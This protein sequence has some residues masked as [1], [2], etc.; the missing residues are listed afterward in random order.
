[1][2]HNLTCS[3]I[4][5]FHSIAMDDNILYEEYTRK[6]LRYKEARLNARWRLFTRRCPNVNDPH[7]IS[8]CQRYENEARLWNISL[9]RSG[10]NYTTR[11]FEE[12]WSFT[13]TMLTCSDCNAMIRY[14][15]MPKNQRSGPPRFNICCHYGQVRLDP[16]PAPAPLLNSLFNNRACV[17]NIRTY[18]SMM[19]FTS[20]S[21]SMWTSY[22]SYK[23]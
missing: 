1:M 9:S 19:S 17:E 4:I 14:D 16:L 23:R 20:I 12:R 7:Y 13:R 22:I 3:T 6:R 8:Q 18:K 10:R 15:E 11:R 5:L 2:I 21:T